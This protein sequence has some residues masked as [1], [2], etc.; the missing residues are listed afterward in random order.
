MKRIIVAAFAIAFAASVAACSNK[1]PAGGSGGGDSGIAATVNGV[2]ITMEDLNKAAKDR[3]ARVDT[4]VYQIRKKVLDSLVEEKIIAEAAKKKGVSVEKFLAEEVESK[5]G[6]PT[7]EEVKA[8]YDARKGAITKPFDEVKGQIAEYLKANRRAQARGELLAKLREDAEVKIEL[9]PPR[10]TLEIP[11]GV[12]AVGDKDAKITVVEF[13]DYQCPFCKRARPTVWRL[14]D[15][16]K[17]KLR[18][19]F[20]D[21]PLS[22]HKDSKKAHEAARCAGDQGKYYEFNRK[23]YD[24]QGK[25]G[26]EDLKGYA[27]ELKLDTAKFDKCLDSGEKAKVVE[28]FIQEGVASGVSGTPSFFING[29]MLSGAQPYESFKEIIDSELKR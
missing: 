20:L 5:A 4:E 12:P 10:V 21:F 15:E 17:D 16:Y 26:I 25:I 9:S 2:A 27:K 7:E 13:S 24:N 6:E 28:E 19:V 8:L 14:V 18:Y 23:V 22:F 1:C 29:I 11:E 3:L